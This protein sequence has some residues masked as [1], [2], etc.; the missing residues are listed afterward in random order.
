MTI[1]LQEGPVCVCVWGGAEA[2]ITADVGF[3]RLTPSDLPVKAFSFLPSHWS[4]SKP[5]HKHNQLR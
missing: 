2:H 5:R 3:Q 1:V 4:C